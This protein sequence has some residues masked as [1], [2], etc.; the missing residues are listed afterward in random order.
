MISEE[1]DC[2]VCGN[3]SKEVHYK[4]VYIC[5]DCHDRLDTLA[6]M[7]SSAKNPF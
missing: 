2:Y 6:E 4:T 1:K 3:D 5:P 7:Q